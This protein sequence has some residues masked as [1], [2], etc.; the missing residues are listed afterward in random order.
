[1]RFGGGRE[2]KQQLDH[3]LH[4]VLLGTAMA[5]HGTLDLGGR[6]LDDLT[7]GLDGGENGDA[8]R[9]AELQRGA[10]VLAMKDVFD[11]NRVRTMGREQPR[12]LEV[13][14]RQAVGERIG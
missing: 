13:N 8:A 4:L 6:V 14:P 7:A 3:V 5:D 11:G 2:S 10:R 12:Q 1:V 9:V